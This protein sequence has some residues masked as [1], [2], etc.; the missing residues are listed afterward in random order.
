MQ[1]ALRLGKWWVIFAARDEKTF[2]GP[3]I[4]CPQ[5]SYENTFAYNELEW[6]A[7][8][9]VYFITQKDNSI[10]LKYVLALL[11]SKLYYLWL[12][13]RGKRKGEM[14]EI[15]YTPL[16]E[17]PI[18]KISTNEQ[19]PF[20]S[21]VD[22]IQSIT[23]DEDYLLN[24]TKQAKVRQYER[25]IDQMVYKLYGLTKEEIAIVENSGS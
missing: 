2:S 23:K 11:N 13:H 15:F 1:A 24:C 8:A 10:N 20:I 22:K 21:L 17:V 5:R 12:Y 4:I 14:L 25:Q 9:D 7:S 6:F 3:K 19:G 16:S 18:K